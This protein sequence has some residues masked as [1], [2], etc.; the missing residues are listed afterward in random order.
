M[1]IRMMA[2]AANFAEAELCAARSSPMSIR[3]MAAAASFV[4][5]FR[6]PKAPVFDRKLRAGPL[7][8]TYFHL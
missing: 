5:V 3:M 2:A 1:S 8:I 7:A 6:A 4:E